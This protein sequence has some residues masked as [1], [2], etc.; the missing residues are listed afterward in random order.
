ME[1]FIK[2]VRR[3]LKDAGVHAYKKKTDEVVEAAKT[4]LNIV[5]TTAIPSDPSQYIH[6]IHS[7]PPKNVVTNHGEIDAPG[8]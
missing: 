6:R 3:I 5:D 7:N 2:E 4:H 1:D 8:T